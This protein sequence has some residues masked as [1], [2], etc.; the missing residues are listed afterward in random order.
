MTR[1]TPNMD[2]FY[3][4]NLHPILSG[5]HVKDISKTYFLYEYLIFQELWNYMDIINR[6]PISQD[7]QP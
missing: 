2:T 5:F 4:V 6:N 3:A 1:K 7:L